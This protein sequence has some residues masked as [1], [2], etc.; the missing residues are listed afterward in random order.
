MRILKLLLLPLI[1]AAASR[2]YAQSAYVDPS[3]K[4]LLEPQ[5]QAALRRAAS[6]GIA[7]PLAPGVALRKTNPLDVTRVSLFAKIR[8]SAAL[9][10]LKS[11]GAT[12]G[13]RVGDIVT[14]EVPLDKI[15]SLFDSP[16]FEV[17][18]ASHTVSVSTDT[19][20]RVIGADLVRRVS[21]GSWTGTAGSGVLIGVYDTGLDFTHDDF[22]DTAGM[23][24]VLA[25]WD[26]TD[27]TGTAP[28]GFSYGRLCSRSEIQQSIQAPN[29]AACPQRDRSGHGTHVAGIAASDGA[30]YS[31]VAPL[32]DLLIVKGGD[33]T[34]SESSIV[35]GLVWLEQQARA[36]NRPIAVNVSIGGQAGPHDGTRLYELIVDQLSRNGFVVVFSAGNDG[37]N[38]NDKNRDGTE[39][40]RTTRYFHGHAGR[41]ARLHDRCCAVSAGRWRMQRLHQF[42]SLV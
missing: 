29:A 37:I 42:Q 32:A 5:V 18:E 1:L 9:E 34:F 16:H 26:Q 8:D 38:N 20:M 31:G 6:I 15:Q 2:S 30:T 3:L 24:R 35:D 40:S 25:L 27:G 11:A 33:G 13:S 19:S 7:D 22:R 36:L 10:E 28:A 14:A 12:V 41:A 4:A 23:T 17:F 21:N 39:P